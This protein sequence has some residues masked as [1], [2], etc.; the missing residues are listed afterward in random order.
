M[1]PFRPKNCKRGQHPTN[2]QANK[3][4]LLPELLAALFAAAQPTYGPVAKPIQSSTA[5]RA[6]SSFSSFSPHLLLLVLGSGMGAVPSISEPRNLGCLARKI[7]PESA[8]PTDLVDT[9]TSHRI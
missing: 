8:Q 1:P 4:I 7:R 5:E 2:K 3:S 9:L 6:L